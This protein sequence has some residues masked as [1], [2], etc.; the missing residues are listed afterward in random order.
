[1]N[2][3]F[4]LHVPILSNSI[5]KYYK[6]TQAVDELRL[7]MRNHYLNKLVLDETRLD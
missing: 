1:M 3:D 7:N 5:P 2:T 6:F 4:N